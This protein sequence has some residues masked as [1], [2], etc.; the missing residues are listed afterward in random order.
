MFSGIEIGRR[1]LM[2]H[3]KALDTTGHNVAN[4]NTPG[5]SRQEVVF[6]SSQPIT[7]LTFS[8]AG[9]LGQMGTGVEAADLKRYRDRFLDRQFRNESTALGHWET[10]ERALREVEAIMAEPTEAGLRAVM[11]QFWRSLQDL[12]NDP[13]SSSARALVR[14]R[15]AAFT[16]QLNNAARFLSELRANIEADIGREAREINLLADRVAS[17]NRQISTAL[18][19]GDKPND[20]MDQRDILLDQLSKIVDIRVTAQ[21]DGKVDV[22]I[23]GVPLVT[24]LTANHMTTQ[25][26]SGKVVVKWLTISADVAVSGGELKGLIDAR[27]LEIDALL[28]K[29]DNLASTFAASFNSVHATGYGLDSSTGNNFFSPST[30]PTIT[31]AT[32]SINPTI[33]SNT[34]K[35]AAA[36]TLDGM[37]NVSRG[38][39]A[40]AFD[41]A[42][43]REN[44][45]FNGGTTN[46]PDYYE[47]VISGLAVSAQAAANMT[48]NQEVLVTAITNQRIALSGVSLDDEMIAMVKY[49]HGYSAAARVI[50][51]MDEL[52]ETIINRMGVVGR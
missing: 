16:N 36:K 23:G 39:G 19:S 26:V 48:N 47:S 8:K 31:A 30:G 46:T 25:V 4:A 29:L 51:A 5:Y 35:I 2:A 42:K 33:V 17:L 52:M 27:D 24:Q 44:L 13:D 37:G 22:H 18:T 45:I 34:N 7:A 28:G 11:D 21:T 15:G 12:A 50:T 43:V 10:K 32:I 40:N 9:G 6:S 41:L 38:D 1:A 3:Q 14:E 49:Q 20:L